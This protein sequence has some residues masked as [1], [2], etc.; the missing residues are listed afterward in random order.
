MPHKQPL[1]RYILELGFL[2]V[3]LGASL[4]LESGPWIWPWI[5]PWIMPQ[6]VP[7]IPVSQILVYYGDIPVKRPYEPIIPLI[8]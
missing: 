4:G 1:N 6:L 7:W 8:P 3:G 2:E 5:W